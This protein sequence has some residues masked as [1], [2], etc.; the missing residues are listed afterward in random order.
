MALLYSK[1]ASKCQFS[2]DLPAIFDIYLVF[3]EV[4]ALRYE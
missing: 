1:N 4:S 2:R 3:N